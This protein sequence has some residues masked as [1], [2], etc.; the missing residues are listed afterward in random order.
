VHGIR[1]EPVVV[2]DASTIIDTFSLTAFFTLLSVTA[3]NGECE[4]EFVS[5]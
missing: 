1:G 3:Q 5:T 4:C 2:L